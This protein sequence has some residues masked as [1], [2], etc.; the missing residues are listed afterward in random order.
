MTALENYILPLAIGA[1]ILAVVLSAGWLKTGR[2]ALLAGAVVAA[3]GS[4]GLFVLDRIVITEQERIEAT[5][6]RIAAEVEGGDT[7]RLLQYIHPD[8]VETR[9]QAEAEMPR[10]AI[11]SV[12]VKRGIQVELNPK[13]DPPE[14]RVSF[15]V[16]VDGGDA[17]G[18]LGERQIPRFVELRMWKDGEAWKVRDYRHADPLESLRNR[19]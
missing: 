3:L 6:H 4:L 17:A 16:V 19:P 8:A 12:R 5:I 18:F 14:A 7:Q 2:R 1:G 9:A 15:N 11:K 10:Y 13:H